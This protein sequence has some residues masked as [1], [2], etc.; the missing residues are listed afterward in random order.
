MTTA[1]EEVGGV[2]VAVAVPEEAKVVV[3]GAAVGMLEEAEVVVAGAEGAE[4][5]F[6]LREWRVPWN[7]VNRF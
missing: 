6:M 7:D 2:D 4:G 5:E 3:A 1:E